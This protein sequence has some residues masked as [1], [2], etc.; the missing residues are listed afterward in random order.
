MWRY[1]S[2]FSNIFAETTNLTSCHKEEYKYC[3][4]Y[5][6]FSQYDEVL[7]EYNFEDHSL[8]SF[9]ISV[10]EISHMVLEKEKGNEVG[11][12]NKFLLTKESE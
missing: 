7:M 11:L 5:Y 1:G 4:P 10:V 3:H 6:H 12:C 8:Y 9:N 2:F